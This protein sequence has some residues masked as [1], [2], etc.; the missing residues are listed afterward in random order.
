MDR[1][2][3]AKLRRFID[4]FTIIGELRKRCR[5]IIEQSDVGIFDVRVYPLPPETTANVR[6]EMIGGGGVVDLLNREIK[7]TGMPAYAEIEEK[8][9]FGD[10]V[11]IHVFSEKK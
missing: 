7:N 5:V 3:I 10:V 2:E 4:S 9:R 8:P 6:E 1:V 11:I